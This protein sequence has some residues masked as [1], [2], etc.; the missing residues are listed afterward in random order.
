MKH[1]L[2]FTKAGKPVWARHG[3]EEVTSA[4]MGILYTMFSIV[5]ETDD[6]LHEIELGGGRKM[7]YYHVE[8]LILGIIFLTY[9]FSKKL[10]SVAIGFGTGKKMN[11]ELQIVRDQ[12]LSLI[13]GGEIIRRYEISSTFDLRRFIHGSERFLHS[14]CD[15][16]ET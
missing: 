1:V 14:I 5:E 7:V 16:I 3:D 10:L 4:L 12:I 15:S 8:P 11:F 2:V 6:E 13:S 9:E